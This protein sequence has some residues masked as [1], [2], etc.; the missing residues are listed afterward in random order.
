MVVV[1]TIYSTFLRYRNSIS[2]NWG[3]P[4]HYNTIK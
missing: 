4:T 1:Y 3:I 2:D